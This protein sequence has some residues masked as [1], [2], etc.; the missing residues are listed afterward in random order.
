MLVLTVSAFPAPTVLLA[1]CEAFSSAM[2]CCPTLCPSFSLA[3]ACALCFQIDFDYP[4]HSATL[5][6]TCHSATLHDTT[7][8][9]PP[10]LHPPSCSVQARCPAPQTTLCPFVSP[11]CRR[12]VLPPEGTE[13]LA[14]LSHLATLLDPNSLHLPCIHHTGKKSF[15]FLPASPPKP[16][17]STSSAPT[18][19]LA[20]KEASSSA[21]SAFM[22]PRSSSISPSSL[23]LSSC[24][25]SATHIW[26]KR[27]SEGAWC[28]RSALKRSRASHPRTDF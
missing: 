24:R 11:V 7:N 8:L 27:G 2:Y 19:L 10:P 3:S 12:S 26:S 28:R 4:R 20:A 22:S 9:S 23:S 1:A 17:E 15:R 21:N 14:F 25:R 13:I 18:V 5:L 6:D 16:I